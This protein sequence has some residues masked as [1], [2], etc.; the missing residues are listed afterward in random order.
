[1]E[2]NVRHQVISGVKWN[3][4]G[5]F[6]SQGIL[7]F[8]SIILARILLPEE[9]GLIGMLFIFTGISTVFIGSGLGAA[10]IKKKNCTNADFST[11][12]FYN[13]AVSLVFFV[14]MFFS[15]PYIATFYNEPELTNIARITSFLFVI[16]AFGMIQITIL[17]KELQFKTLNMIQIVAVIISAAVSIFMA[18]NDFGVYSLVWQQ[19]IF[20]LV[21]NLLYWLGSAWKPALVFSKASFRELFG[22]G[23]RLLLSALLDQIYVTIDSM[24]IGKIFNAEQLGY[25]TRAKST[26]DMPVSNSTGILT[27][28]VFPIFA[29]D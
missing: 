18:Y 19:I 26:R 21:A 24:L 2:N 9:F 3:A 4:V 10:L 7:F 13:I 6:G 8:V 11:V 29:K 22:F 28:I 17:Q 1:M 27:K 16:N 15:A 14:A 25:Y 20:A 12:F 5:Q 23:S